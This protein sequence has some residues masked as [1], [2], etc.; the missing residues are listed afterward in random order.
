MAKQI[1][2]GDLEQTLLSFDFVMSE[3][4]E[5]Y[6][7]FRHPHSE[8]VLLLPRYRRDKSAHHFHL[9]SVRG[10]LADFGFLKSEEFDDIV[11]NHGRAA[12]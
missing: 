1:T 8:A 10:T 9:S 11:R 5:G 4:R 3:T 6:R 12:S 2:Y 7:L